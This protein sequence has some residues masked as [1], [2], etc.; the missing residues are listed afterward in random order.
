MSIQKLT[1]EKIRNIKCSN[2]TIF[3]TIYT[4]YVMLASSF[5]K[6]EDVMG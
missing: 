6:F 1:V 4:M 3:H 2:D 5:D